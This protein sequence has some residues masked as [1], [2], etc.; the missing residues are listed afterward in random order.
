MSASFPRNPNVGDVFTA[1]NGYAYQYTSKGLWKIIQAPNSAGLK[2]TASPT[3]P[4]TPTLGDQWYDTVNRSLKGYASDGV[5]YFWE[6]LGVAPYVSNS[7]PTE[8]VAGTLWYNSLT[9]ELY[10][11]IVLDPKDPKSGSWKLLYSDAKNSAD[12]ILTRW[13]PASLAYSDEG[14]VFEFFTNNDNFKWR[15]VDPVPIIEAIAGNSAITVENTLGFKTGVNYTI[16]DANGKCI[17]EVTVESILTTTTLRTR[18]PLTVSLQAG[19]KGKIAN[20]S[21]AVQDGSAVVSDGDVFFSKELNVLRNW[22]KGFVVIRRTASGQGIFQVQWRPKETL[23]WLP[24]ELT[25]TQPVF[26]QKD[27]RDE[28]YSISHKGNVEIRIKY[29]AGAGISDTVY[30]LGLTTATMSLENSRIET[31]S[32]VSPAPDAVGLT[33]TPTLTGSTYRSLYDIAQGGAEFRLARDE[34]MSNLVYSTSSDFLASWQ[35]ISGQTGTLRDMLFFEE[36]SGIIVGAQKILL[37]PNGGTSFTS[38]TTTADLHAVAYNKSLT[39]SVSIVVGAAGYI[40]H[41]ANKGQSW[42]TAASAGGFSGVLYGVA[43]TDLTAVAVGESGMILRSIN[44][45]VI[46]AS[47]PPASGFLKAFYDIAMD[48]NGNCVAVGEEGTI[49]TSNNFGQSWLKRPVANNFTGTFRAVAMFG[50]K[51]I[52]VGANGTIQTSTDYGASWTKRTP[53]GNYANSF[54]AVSIKDDYVVIS[55][56]AGEIQTSYDGGQTWTKRII[57]GGS[58]VALNTAMIAP[59][60]ETYAMLAGASGNIQ[61]TMLLTGATTSITVPAGPDILQV[62]EV[63]WWSCRYRDTVGYWSGWSKPTAFATKNDFN[64]VRQCTN[65]SPAN[66]ALGIS[67]L[68]TLQTS[69]FGYLGAEDQHARTQWQVSTSKDF[70]TPLYNS[71]DSADLLAHALPEQYR[72]SN[73]VKYFWRA[74]HKGTIGGGKYGPWSEP[75]S[76]TAVAKPSTP[77]LTAPAE[78]DTSVSLVPTLRSS[79]F[80]ISSPGISHLS[81][82]WQ[83]A[84]N[85]SFS[86]VVIDS[87]EVNSLT[88]FAVTAGVLKAAT[89]Y[90]ARVR[91]KGI[92]T[93]YSDWST[94][95]GFACTSVSVNAPT[96]SVSSVTTSSAT[97][98]SGAF[99]ISGAGASDTHLSTDWEVRTAANGGG[100]LVFS[101]MGNATAKTV[102]SAGGLPSNSD[103]FARVRHRGQAYGNSEWS[104]DFG[105]KTPQPVGQQVY[106][107]VGVHQFIVPAGVTSV[108]AVAVGGGSAGATAGGGG[109]ALAFVNNWVVTPGQAITVIVGGAG[110]ISSFA[111]AVSAGGGGAASSYRYESCSR[112]GG[113]D[114]D[115]SMETGYTGG[116]GGKP[117]GGTGFAGGN[118]GDGNGGGGGGGAGGYAGAGG[119]GGRG[120]AGSSSNESGYAGSGGA[121]GGGMGGWATGGGGGVGLNGIGANGSG[122]PSG[123]TGGAGGG[124]SG[125]AAANGPSGGI[126]GGGGGGKGG[127][128]TQGAVR[129]IWGPNRNFPNNAA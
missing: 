78:G 45:G 105:F 101:S 103:L 89:S 30:H 95:V 108:S 125:G 1:P 17:S 126:Y 51:V 35:S 40:A 85:S 48:T 73:N 58:N 124:G 37:T 97:L 14:A 119:R 57:G 44:G 75:T 65:L 10:Y 6:P 23:T 83:I 39:S 29:S 15:S 26:E 112:S 5:G 38:V 88:S 92:G 11:W 56:E 74:R 34:L 47:V 110:G 69:A 12:V 18:E 123:K 76:F 107:A 28:L 70:N 33:A 72:L 129:I 87:G 68:P 116:A 115:C 91:H 13:M 61:K 82:Q 59:T 25:R 96:I 50:S 79:G 90:F 8:K 106:T 41:S 46:W 121:G 118:G 20:T 117:S 100:Q 111:G 54:L 36:M 114:Y 109:G 32:N 21:F 3:A 67:A 102:V 84:T 9:N 64:S 60:S 7:E 49:Q 104:N 22:S 4:I 128:G 2:F 27:Q 77:A 122:G 86:N 71:N 43:T 99:G 93:D 19:S 80:A 98:T 94:V 24:L 55:G 127:Q 62:N 63:Y 53:D 42:T 113:G 52:A 66:E 16:E 120:T 31:P 81:S